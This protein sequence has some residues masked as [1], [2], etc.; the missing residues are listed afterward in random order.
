MF[1]VV[2]F[3]VI[4]ARRRPHRP[5]LGVLLDHL[6]ALD[7]HTRPGPA[8][9]DRCDSERA[10]AVQDEVRRQGC[11]LPG[12]APGGPGVARFLLFWKKMSRL[13]GVGKVGVD[14]AGSGNVE[15]EVF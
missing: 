15:V 9:V 3:I 4:P 6:L 14:R 5:P 1:L 10:P 7:G 2:I 8:R 13:V 11:D 12:Q